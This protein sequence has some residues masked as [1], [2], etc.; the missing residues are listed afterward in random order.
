MDMTKKLLS[1]FAFLLLTNY[2]VFP[3]QGRRDLSAGFPRVLRRWRAGRGGQ[4][5]IP[6][7]GRGAGKR[8]LQ[9]GRARVR[10]AFPLRDVPKGAW[11]MGG[12]SVERRL[13]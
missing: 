5:R 2:S 4:G 1:V 11:R 9:A 7:T 13:K 8:T 3:A 10:V 6:G 12:H